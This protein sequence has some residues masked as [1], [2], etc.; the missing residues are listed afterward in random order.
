MFSK[1]AKLGAVAVSAAAVAA[2]TTT[3]IGTGQALNG[4]VTANFSWI[5]HGGTE[6]T[7]T[8]QLSNGSVYQGQYFQVTQE[9]RVDDFGPLWAGWGGWG[10]GGGWGRGYYGRGWGWG[11]GGWGP[12][13]PYDQTITQYT[14][15]VLANLTGPAGH[16]R[17]HFTLARPSSGMAGGGLGQCQL[18]T[19]VIIDAQFPRGAAQYH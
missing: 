19:G 8:A 15:Q 12:W 6:G 5:E 11:W 1:L 13:G 2:C 10:W 9:S 14:G 3:G 18:P 16:M 17:C 7:M 4:A